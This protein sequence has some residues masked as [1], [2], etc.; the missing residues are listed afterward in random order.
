V[1]NKKR[2][3]AAAKRLPPLPPMDQWNHAT[4]LRTREKIRD[5]IEGAGISYGVYEGQAISVEQ[6][7]LERATAQDPTLRLRR[8][9]WKVVQKL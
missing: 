3:G 2:G 1:A 6:A 9:L 5:A 7:Y 8:T 4:A